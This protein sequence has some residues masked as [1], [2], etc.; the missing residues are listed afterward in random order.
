[1]A[2]V[3]LTLRFL[4]R[5]PFFMRN[6]FPVF[7]H[8]ALDRFR[9]SIQWKPASFGFSEGLGTGGPIVFLTRPFFFFPSRRCAFRVAMVPFAR[10][11]WSSLSD[12]LLWFTR[13][14]PAEKGIVPSFPLLAISF[15]RQ[16]GALSFLFPPEQLFGGGYEIH[17]LHRGAY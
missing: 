6:S 14:L 7:R 2:P 5:F 10:C 15:L 11:P 8:L 3:M 12:F 4:P 1:L 17:F 13:D 9:P 16:R